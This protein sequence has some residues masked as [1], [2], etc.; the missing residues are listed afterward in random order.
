FL[1]SC[2][3][4]V[5]L[6]RDASITGSDVRTPVSDVKNRRGIG[7]VEAPRGTLIHDYSVNEKGFIERCNLIVATCQ[8]NY[9][10]D[11]SVEAVAKKVVQNGALTENA[12]NRIEMV[13]RAYD[14]CISCATHAIGRM[15]LHIEVVHRDRLRANQKGDESTC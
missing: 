5:A 7:I 6:L 15:P 8:N 11:R 1:S 10:M 13:I 4:A 14:P 12:A 2:E 3:R 9:A